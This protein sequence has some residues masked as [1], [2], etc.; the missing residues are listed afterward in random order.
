[1]HALDVLGQIE[2]VERGVRAQF[3][4]E[5]GLWSH[6][7]QLA[8]DERSILHV[9]FE[10]RLGVLLV[11]HDERVDIALRVERADVSTHV[12]QAVRPR[13]AVRTQIWL[14]AVANQ[15]AVVPRGARRLVATVRTTPQL[16]A[17]AYLVLVVGR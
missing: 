17:E 14:P 2:L 10:R 8:V 15:V 16:R 5:L 12:G 11:E 9:V 1:M 6:L 13:A 7:F 3:A 4:L